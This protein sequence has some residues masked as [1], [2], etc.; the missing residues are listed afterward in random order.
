VLG[1]PRLLESLHAVARRRGQ[2]LATAWGGRLKYLWTGS[3]PID[4]ALL[5]DYD[6]AGVPVFEGY[7]MTETGMIAKNYPG[8]RRISSVGQPFPEKEV[9]ISEDGEVLVRSEFHAADCYLRGE[10]GVFRPDGWI[11]TGDLGRFDDDGYLY[12]VGRCKDTLVLQS[13]HKVH[14]PQLEEALRR[15]PAIADCAV[16]GH[17]RPH[18][19]AVVELRT[20]DADVPAALDR[21][22]AVAAAHERVHG[23]VVSPPFADA[24]LTT[25]N[26]KLNRAAITERFRDAL[27]QLYRA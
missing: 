4:R 6:R 18:Q 25:S 5:E 8:R 24:G 20:A 12:L 21:H 22:N 17:G 16:V 14:P 1:V 10:T 27:E 19:V 26:G 2:D 7:G 23:Y 9:R 11:A 13:G 15:E 3:A